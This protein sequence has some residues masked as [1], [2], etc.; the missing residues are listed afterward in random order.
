MRLPSSFLSTLEMLS[1]KRVSR[2]SSSSNARYTCWQLASGEVVMLHFWPGFKLIPSPILRCCDMFCSNNEIQMLCEIWVH[3]L[4]RKCVILQ[5]LQPFFPFC[6]PRWLLPRNQWE[7]ASLCCPHPSNRARTPQGHVQNPTGL[8]L[9][10]SPEYLGVCPRQ[11]SRRNHPGSTWRPWLR[12]RFLSQ[13]QGPTQS[14]RGAVAAVST[15]LEVT[16]RHVV[17]PVVLLFSYVFLLLWDQFYWTD[18]FDPFLESSIY[19]LS[20]QPPARIN[21]PWNVRANHRTASSCCSSCAGP[22]KLRSPKGSSLS[23]T[24]QGFRCEAKRKLTALPL[25]TSAPM[26]PEKKQKKIESLH[27]FLHLFTI[28]TSS[29][30]PATWTKAPGTRYAMTAA[31]RPRGSKSVSCDLCGPLH[32]QWVLVVSPA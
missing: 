23:F 24:F 9:P 29:W 19:S 21:L 20:M 32:S 17:Q 14:R 27:I 11:C 30:L 18:H 31:P 12:L 22:S 8:W 13:I 15:H 5:H 4:K 28:F 10:T 6:K 16:N 2:V 25:C 7:H 3:E 26:D 1:P